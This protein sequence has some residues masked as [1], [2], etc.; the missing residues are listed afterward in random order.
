MASGAWKVRL[1]VVFVVVYNR[2]ARI[3]DLCA[4]EAAQSA[5]VTSQPAVR[6]SSGG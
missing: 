1:A 4:D 6:D 5:S 3:V 2:V